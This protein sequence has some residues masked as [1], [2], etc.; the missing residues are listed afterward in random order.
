LVVSQAVLQQ[1]P[2]PLMPQTPE[3]QAS[4]SVQPPLAMGVAHTP[5]LQTKP[6][7]QSALEAHVLL[8]LVALVQ[9]K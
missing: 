2:R 3:V 6:V 8:Q 4:F 1:L 5:P 9:V 7:A